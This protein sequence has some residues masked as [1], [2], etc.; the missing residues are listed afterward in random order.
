MGNICRW[1]AEQAESLGIEI[2]P[3]FAA[4]ELIKNEDGS[5]GGV[6]TGDMGV[7]KDGSEK[8]GYMPGMELRAKYTL[9]AEG[10]RGHLGKQLLQ[11]FQLD[12][13]ATPNISVSALKKSGIFRLNNTN[14]VKLYIPQAGLLMTTVQE[15]VFISCR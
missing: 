13:D 3:G 5:I 14:R 4:S 12:K 9:F 1:L 10:C 15:G 8:D 11:Q 6:I 2:F 7:A